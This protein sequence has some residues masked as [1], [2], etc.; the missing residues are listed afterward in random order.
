MGL[1]GLSGAS[2]DAERYKYNMELAAA[3]KAKVT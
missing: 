1:G 2:G 3:P